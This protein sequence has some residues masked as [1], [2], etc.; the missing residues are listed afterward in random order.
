MTHEH[1]ATDDPRAFWDDR[2][3]ES[4]RIWSGKVNAA[5]ADVA[6]GLAPG[7]ALDLGCGEGGDSI[8]LAERGW[9]VTG[10]D[11]SD[12]ALAR[13]ADAAAERRVTDRVH[14]VS[15]DLGSWAP[16]DE[17]DLVTACFFQSPITL[18]RQDILRRVAAAIRPGGHLLVIGHASTPSWSPETL[19]EGHHGSPRLTAT[20]EVEALALPDPE[21]SIEIAED[22]SRPITDPEGEPATILDSVV[23]ARRAG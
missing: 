13:A 15:A 14:W 7:R 18:S 22:R 5:L 12:V 6:A 21:W 17:Y 19:D 9:T 8:W 2:Y 10:V 16:G 11:I 4:D 3:S 20:E 23:L 1:F